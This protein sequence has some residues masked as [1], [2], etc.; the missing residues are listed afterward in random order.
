M[1]KKIVLPFIVLVACTAGNVLAE[2]E[3]QFHRARPGR[4]IILRDC[5]LFNR[6]RRVG[7]LNGGESIA[8]S[9][10]VR[11]GTFRLRRRFRFFA[12]GQDDNEQVRIFV[13]R[14]ADQEPRMLR[15]RIRHFPRT[16]SGGGSSSTTCRI[17][18]PNRDGPGGWLH[19]PVSDSTRS[20]VNLFPPQ[21]RPTNCRYER[22][23]GSLFT[24]GYS[25]GRHNGN[26]EHIRPQGGGSCSR[27]PANMVLNCNIAGTRV[28]Y[29]IPNPCVRYD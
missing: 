12:C 20:I 2:E 23:D 27:F 1:L 11:R 21:D 15:L 25:S 22:S 26:R 6:V 28:C 10:N 8:L 3:L 19:K 5:Q 17:Y 14:R 18:R 24:T 16:Q 4:N 13:K 29:R 7:I 9:R